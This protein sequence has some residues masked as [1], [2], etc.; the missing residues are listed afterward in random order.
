MTVQAVVDAVLT[1]LALLLFVPCSVLFLQ[2][3]AA[4]LTRTKEPS[5]AVLATD[6]SIAVLMPA[7]DEEAGIAYSIRS[8]LGQLR[9]GDRLLVIA[10]N[11]SDRT[12]A[13]ARSLGAEVVERH[14]EQL[15]GKG[16]ALDHGVRALKDKPP[17]VVVV[18]DAD[19]TLAPGALTLVAG[20]CLAAGC[21]AQALYLMHAPQGAPLGLRVSAFAWLVKNKLRPLGGSRLGWPCQL[22]GTGMAFP[23]DVL[24]R[25][26]LASGHLVEDMQLGMALTRAG[27]PPIHCPQAIVNGVFPS[28]PAGVASQRIRWE[29]GH[30]SIIASELPLSLW[31]A[32]RHLDSRLMLMALDLAVPP[33]ASLVLMLVLLFVVAAAWWSFVGGLLPLVLV[34]VSLVLVGSAV[35]LAWQQEGRRVLSVAELVYLPIYIATKVPLYLRLFTQRQVQWVRTKRDGREH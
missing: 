26:S 15:R 22:M 27:T 20:A 8:V 30:L 28:D 14:D 11:C 24:S 4:F 35:A 23:W 29:H 16:Y 17:S 2:L 34:G 31:R 3:T 33:L 25:A 19:C 12:A 1:V 5:A 10:D 7:H 6:D 9:A 18:V 21:P 32:A 13:L